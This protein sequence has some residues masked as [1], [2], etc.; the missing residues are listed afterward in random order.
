MFISFAVLLALLGT[1]KLPLDASIA[2]PNFSGRWVLDRQLT[3]D[4]RVKAGRNPA[5]A[6]PASLLGKEL[7][8]AQDNGALTVTLL[9]LAP[10]VTMVYRFDGSETHNTTVGRDAPIEER[11]TAKWD[12]DV[13]VVRTTRIGA[14]GSAALASFVRK[15]SIERDVLII[16]TEVRTGRI[17]TCFR[18]PPSH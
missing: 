10:N 1:G 5:E 12:G 13:L 15:W 16:T 17:D 4:R 6:G 8:I 9:S 11:S 2:R 14:R 7:V 3:T 18:R